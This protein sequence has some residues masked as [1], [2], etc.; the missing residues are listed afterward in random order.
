MIEDFNHLC[1]TR[2]QLKPFGGPGDPLVGDFS[3][4]YL[5]KKWRPD[6]PYHEEAESALSEA[7]RRYKDE[8]ED[9]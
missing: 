5:I 4:A 6:G 3:G 7:Y 9:P 8:G 1:D 2:W